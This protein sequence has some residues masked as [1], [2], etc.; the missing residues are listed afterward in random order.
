MRIYLMTDMEG[1][2]GILNWADWCSPEG[3]YYEKGKALLTEEVNA[4]VEGFLAGGATDVTVS[5]GHGH[6]GIEPGLLHPAAR[7]IRGWPESWPFLLDPEQHDAV[8]WVGQHAKAGTPFAHLAHTQGFAYRDE[9][10]NGVSIGELGQFALCAGELGVRAIFA[11]GD[12]AMAEEARALIPGIETVAVKRGTQ[13]DPGHHLPTSAYALHNVA[14]VHLSVEEARRLI[15]EGAQRAVERARREDFG[16]LKLDPPYERVTVLRSDRTN[17]PRV[18]RTRHAAS[19][20]E[21]FRQPYD[22]VPIRECD[23]LTSV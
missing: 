5:D 4:A 22:F 11:A 18:S 2:C 17:P 6:G 15:R 9:S 3:R 1:V 23:P 10:V 12:R 21:L 14:A 13:P 19:I 8:A 7:L 20:I 16:L